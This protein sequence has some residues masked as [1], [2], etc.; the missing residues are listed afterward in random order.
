MVHSEDVDLRERSGYQWKLGGFREGPMLCG[1]ERVD[2]RA[3]FPG[4]PNAALSR[5]LRRLGENVSPNTNL[6]PLNQYLGGPHL[7]NPLSICHT[8]GP[9]SL[10]FQ[11]SKYISIML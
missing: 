5:K 7:L 6:T 4:V 11:W 2:V 3:V 1:A 9:L 8:R 10:S